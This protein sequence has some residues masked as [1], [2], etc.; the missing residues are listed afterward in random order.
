M[1]ITLKINYSTSYGQHVCVVGSLP[2]LG[3]GVR[4][5]AYSM[6]HEGGGLWTAEIDTLDEK[7][8]TYRYF[9]WTENGGQIDEWGA[10]RSF[11]VPAGSGSAT[12]I[13]QWRVWDRDKTFTASAFTKALIMHEK[14]GMKAA[15]ARGKKVLRLNLFAPRVASGISIAVC[16]G[17]PELGNWDS[18]KAVEMSDENFPLWTAEIKAGSLEGRIEYK[19]LL[20]DSQSKIPLTWEWGDNRIIEL[21]GGIDG[22]LVKDDE[23]YRYAIAD[24]K[25]SGVAIPV[26]SLRS[27]D[28]FGIGEF[29]DLK[30][31]AD[32]ASATGQK[33]IQTLPINDTSRFKTNADSYPYSAISV[34]ALHPIYINPFELGSLPDEGE[35]A[36]FRELQ[37][38]FNDSPTVMYE[39]VLHAKLDYFKQIYELQGAKVLASKA[40]K[41]FYAQSEEWLLPYARFC[42]LRDLNGTADFRQWGKY[43]TYNDSA[44]DTLSKDK[45]ALHQIKFHMYLQYEAHV[46]LSAAIGYA[47]SK[48]VAVKGDIPIGISP[49]S[50]E[51][52]TEPALFNLDS[53]AGAPPD[54]FS[55]TGQ[56]WGFPT[57]NWEEMRS[58]GY[59]WWKKRFRKMGMYF[60]IYRIDHVLGFFRIWRMSAG[61]VQGLLGHFDPA[62]PLSEDEIRGYGSWFEYHRM[63]HPYIREHILRDKF[64]DMAS[65]VKN[66]FLELVAP[67]V[68]RFQKPYANQRLVEKFFAENASELPFSD[69]V[70]KELYEKL[71]SLHAEVL[72]IEDSKKPG[73][74]HPR[75]GM[76]NTYSFRDLDWNTQ[77][78]LNRLYDDFFYHRHDEFWKQQAMQKLPALLHSTDMLCCAEDLG[79][80]PACVPQVMKDLSMLS[81]EIERMPKDPHDEFVPLG[82]IQYLSVCTTSTHDMSPLRLWWEEDREMTQKYFNNILGEHG[83]APYFCEPWVCEKIVARHLYSPAMLVILPLQD[84]LSMDGSVRRQDP[85]EERINQPADPHHFWCYRMHVSLEQLMGFGELNHKIAEL[86]KNSGR[87]VRM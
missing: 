58:D 34:M 41:D 18:S 9:V 75:I 48:G 24:F 45:E 25:C 16:G 7:S 32:W 70:K 60:Q 47:L 82:S 51:A 27:K 76:Q 86:N 21:G 64:G 56:N 38:Q 46:Q 84:W 29:S 49:E 43:A 57:Y 74:F 23:E 67:D 8:F 39:Q 69:E 20:I 37:K 31:M 26:F 72:F 42:Y 11:D 4:T 79:M 62:L 14:S 17:C 54:P 80:I 87:A 5:K 13:D 63:V 36:R 33:V 22:L 81:L 73:L 19:Y 10:D 77:Q 50:V 59:G 6:Y 1:K 12:I 55:E 52:W 65:F 71:L 30:G 35:M 15:K 68:Y 40:Y 85:R 66:T 28:S 78:C 3:N 44:L 83:A 53:Q 2:D 61:D